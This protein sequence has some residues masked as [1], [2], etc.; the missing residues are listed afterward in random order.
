MKLPTCQIYGQNAQCEVYKCSE[1]N[2]CYSTHYIYIC[3][4]NKNKKSHKFAL[5]LLLVNSNSN[6]ANLKYVSNLSIMPG[7]RIPVGNPL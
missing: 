1:Y 6:Q 2:K 7:V 5:S 3:I 4:L